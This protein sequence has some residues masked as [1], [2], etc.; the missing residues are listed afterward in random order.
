M[1]D[2]YHSFP[3]TRGFKKKRKEKEKERKNITTSRRSF[4]SGTEKPEQ[5]KTDEE[6]QAENKVICWCGLER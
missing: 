4:P 3:L 5:K 6:K 1:I 2:S